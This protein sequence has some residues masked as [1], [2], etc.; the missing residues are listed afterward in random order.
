MRKI[1]EKAINK[2][3]ITLFFAIFFSI[4]GII[5]YYFVPKQENPDV[6][7][8]AAII[9]TIYPG[10]TAEDMNK[11][12]A[13]KIED[14]IIDIDGLNH[15]ET[16]CKK[17]VSNILVMLEMDTDTDKAW[18]DLKDKLKAVE[19]QLPEGCFIPQ[20]NTD[21]AETTGIIISLSGEKYSYEQL[22]SYAEDFRD[23]LLTID[24][25]SRIDIIGEVE[26]EVKVQVNMDRL[27]QYDLS[28]E[29]VYKII[30]AENIQLPSGEIQYEDGKMEIIIPQ[31]YDSIRDIEET[32]LMGTRDGGMVRL[33]DIA[34]IYMDLEDGSKKFKQDGKNAILIAGYFKEKENIVLIGKDVRV[35]LDEIKEVFSKDLIIN[36]VMFQ[37]EDVNKSI[38]DFGMNLIQGMAFVIIVVFFITGFKNALVVSAGIPLSVLFTFNIMN[39]LGVDIHFMSTAGLIISLG[40]LVDNGIV[41]ADTIQVN[42]DEGMDKK[43]AIIEGALKSSSPILS[44][45]LTTIG[46][47]LPLLFLP[48]A[49]GKVIGDIPKIVIATLLN[50]YLIAMIMTPVMAYIFLEPSDEKK[51][52][53][54]FKGFFEKLLNMA[55]N[56]KKKAIVIVLLM[57]AFS[58][59]MKNVIGTKFFPYADKN[60]LYINV[61]N[62]VAGDMDKTE[63]LI[64]DIEKILKNTPEVTSTTAAIG[65]GMPKFYMSM[66]PSVPSKDFGQI[67]LRFDLNKGDRFENK[68]ELTDY[69][70]KELDSKIISGKATVK[71]L[72]YGKPIG[73]PIRIRVIGTNYDSIYEDVMKIENILE[74]IEGS[75]NV[76]NDGEKRSIAYAL[77]IDHNLSKKYAISNYDIGRQINIALK[78]NK[79]T[80]FRK[81]GN[82]YDVVVDTDIASLKGLG[83]MKIKSSMTGNKVLLKEFSKTNIKSQINTLK[84]YNGELS[85]TVTSDN[86]FGYSPIDIENIL[87][88]KMDR[89]VFINRVVFDGEREEIDDVFGDMQILFMLAV[90]LI[91]SILLVQFNSFKSPFIIMV[92]IPLSTIGI[93]N[94]LFLMGE[95]LGLMVMLGIISLSGVVVNNGILL[96]EYIEEGRKVGLTLD[97]AC[98]SAVDKRYRPIISTTATTIIGL[99][100]LYLSKNPLFTGMSIALM[101][102]LLIS[103][104]LTM[105]V[106]PTVYSLVN[107]EK[108]FNN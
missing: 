62:E 25:M 43:K 105:I 59:N 16:T 64:M 74:S 103:T 82:E 14:E 67:M 27:N 34:K 97:E 3:K 5:S 9:T 6:S 58:M 104:F 8:P 70:Q 101:S 24:G 48:G 73:N 78:G 52:T 23:E 99:V 108:S 53:I 10:A 80:L 68:E 95:P 1:I 42:L 15:I 38:T 55:L 56:N 91:Y 22:N 88:E 33:K 90:L 85:I 81:S 13:K 47:F 17:G 94:G 93:F 26:K 75:V 83:N 37:P 49:P 41:V 66:F 28:L 30:S 20:L 72:E 100:P 7:L 63:N 86:K 4:T 71:M 51:R 96:I 40:M 77:D 46:A 50:S 57:F 69:L 21:I 44:S 31:T 12:V 106:V 65:D 36:E 19:N 32:I 60:I 45:T 92:S 89:E 54:P 11:L 79:A 98:K 35:K 29:D 84:N 18:D 87:E 39:I 2:R 102:G 61:D 107:K 76:K